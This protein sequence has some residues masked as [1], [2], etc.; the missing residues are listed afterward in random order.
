MTGCRGSS[1][2]PSITCGSCWTS[3]SSG[4]LGAYPERP[5]SI[6]PG[7]EL[8]GLI[9]AGGAGTRLRPLT[10]TSAKQLVP[11]ANKPVLFY[12][13]EAMRDAGIE[14]VTILV[15]PGS[16]GAEIRART[17]DGSDWGL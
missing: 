6:P 8:K 3:R 16:T 10:H 15:S 5:T 13:L 7:M 14:D 17:G 9:L 11:V 12:A 2:S 1:S 4:T